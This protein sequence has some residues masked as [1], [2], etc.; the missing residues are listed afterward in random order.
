MTGTELDEYFKKRELTVNSF[1]TDI[2]Y[3]NIQNPL[4]T[5]QEYVS[6]FQVTPGRDVL[7]YLSLKSHTFADN[8]NYV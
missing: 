5:H 8:T 4:K 1:T 2:Y 3:D 7:H 6:S